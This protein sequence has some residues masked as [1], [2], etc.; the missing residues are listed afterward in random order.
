[1]VELSVFSP[2]WHNF[3]YNLFAQTRRDR[4]DA[5]TIYNKEVHRVNGSAD[6]REDGEYWHITF[7][8]EGDRL[9]FLLKW[10]G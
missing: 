10:S 6:I 4:E 7:D 3:C 5:Q 9:L 2:A 8:T 1:M